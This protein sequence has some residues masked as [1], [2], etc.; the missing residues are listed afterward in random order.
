[1]I[2]K[3][4]LIGVTGPQHGGLAN[5]FFIRFRLLI[6]GARSVRI[7][8][9]KQFDP[10]KLD[11]LIIGGGSDI[12]PG[13]YIP[14]KSRLE[15]LRKQKTVSTSNP[16]YIWFL[17]PLIF[18]FRKFLSKKSYGGTDKER[19]ELEFGLLNDCVQ[20]NI[21][22]LGICRGAQLI[23][24]YFGGSLYQNLKEFYEETPQIN[25]IFPF[26]EIIIEPDTQLSEIIGKQSCFVNALHH[27]A[28]DT[29]GKN[30]KITAH[31]RKTR[32]IQAI[33][34]E[35]MNFI[36]GVQWHPEYM[37]CDNNQHKIFMSLISNCRN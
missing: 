35:K 7:T 28:I 8:A 4:P 20:R 29:T 25:S 13:R 17:Y 5:W 12:D 34:H 32:I 19:D 36:L 31:E 37:L 10:E 9:N 27:Q 15:D 22:V 3:K 26:K 6:S 1:M 18:I 24:V 30:I 14:D 23:N 2:T 21:P 33:E 11:G 16:W